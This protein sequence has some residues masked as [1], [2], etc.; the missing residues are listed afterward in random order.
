[1]K[2]IERSVIL[3][4]PDASGKKTFVNSLGLLQ[5]GTLNNKYANSTRKPFLNLHGKKS[6]EIYEI[7][8]P[9]NSNEFDAI[10][11]KILI[12]RSIDFNSDKNLEGIYN[13]AECID[14]FQSIFYFSSGDDPRV[15]GYNKDFLTK[16]ASVYGESIF[17]YLTIVQSFSDK[18]QYFDDTNKYT[19]CN[20]RDEIKEAKKE[21]ENF[22]KE[23]TETRRNEFYEIL[24][25]ITDKINSRFP[26]CDNFDRYQRLLLNKIAYLDFGK[27]ELIVS[28]SR[29]GKRFDII[30]S[31]SPKY[32]DEFVEDYKKIYGYAKENEIT[33]YDWIDRVKERIFSL[34]KSFSFSKIDEEI[35]EIKK[36]EKELEKD[37]K[38]SLMALKKT[39]NVLTNSNRFGF[40]KTGIRNLINSAPLAVKHASALNP[41]SNISILSSI[42]EIANY[43]DVINVLR[44]VNDN[45]VE[46]STES[47]KFAEFMKIF[48]N[49]KAVLKAQS[50]LGVIE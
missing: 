20:N 46:R 5:A 2:F 37:N 25:I 49:E 28:E 4:G 35:K 8:V 17:G 50:H 48:E 44:I 24:K 30:A 21:I 47:E 39:E 15:Y 16:L 45:Y 22:Y 12:C 36:K 32:P 11:L 29:E 7:L 27:V 43:S 18:I 19:N 34:D 1:M 40:L 14:E 33:N 6:D 3:L 9:F 38:I 10:K 26:D 13:L 41:F 42:S 31:N 23:R